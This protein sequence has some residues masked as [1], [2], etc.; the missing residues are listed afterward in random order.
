MP[1]EH[2]RRQ[3]DDQG[4]PDNLTLLDLSNRRNVRVYSAQ[5][6]WGYSQWECDGDTHKPQLVSTPTRSA[7][8]ERVRPGGS[9]SPTRSVSYE[10]VRPGGGGD[11]FSDEGEL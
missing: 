1:F 9:T 7:S 2:T 10:R 6:A 8:Y 4:R 11:V 5:G 3:T